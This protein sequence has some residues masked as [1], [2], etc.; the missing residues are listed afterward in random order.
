MMQFILFLIFVSIL[1][2]DEFLLPGDDLVAEGTLLVVLEDEEVPPPD[3]VLL[4][5]SLTLH[6]HLAPSLS[7]HTALATGSLMLSSVKWNF[8]VVNS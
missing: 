6:L 8:M 5:Q 4:Q 3:L 7:V 2:F 1:T